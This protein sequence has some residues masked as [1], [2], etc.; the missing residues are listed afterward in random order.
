MLDA[1]KAESTVQPERIK[2]FG[3]DVPLYP[4]EAILFNDDVQQIVKAR[5]VERKLWKKVRNSC[6]FSKTPN[7]GA[8]A[9]NSLS[10][11]KKASKTYLASK[12]CLLAALITDNARQPFKNRGSLRQLIE[13]AEAYQILKALNEPVEIWHQPKSSGGIRT[14]Q[15]FGP[16]ARA[17]QRMVTKLIGLTFEPQ[18][19]QFPNQGSHAKTEAV[20]HLLREEDYRYVIE[21]DIKDFYPSFEEGKL[22]ASLPLPKE[23]I[24]QI[25]LAVDAPRYFPG[26]HSHSFLDQNCPGIP[27]GS[28]SSSEL[29]TWCVAYL[30]TW[31]KVQDVFVV[32]HVDNFFLVG[33]S[34]QAVEFASKALGFQLKKL[35]GGSFQGK[36]VQRRCVDEGFR[37]LGAWIWRE[38]SSIIAHPTEHNLQKFDGRFWIEHEKV[39]AGFKS[40][41]K[42]CCDLQRIFALQDYVR[43]KN[44]V[45]GWCNAFAFCDDIE[46]IRTDRKYLLQQ[47]A[48]QYQ[49]DDAELKAASDRS[50]KV[51]I[52][53]YE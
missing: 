45:T 32:N 1:L 10:N 8:L 13:K 43:L 53:P 5:K 33:R 4:C 15:K 25:I 14:I 50:T 26:G 6:V 44:Y 31:L 39:H 40:A 34:W 17:S 23:A 12:S 29:A 28:V 22:I 21:I 42:D 46:M 24:R 38:G 37:M 27:Q 47:I 35:P 18:D 7:T 9:C 36:K 3:H 41:Q 19:F 51:R 11:F 52:D 49:I 16:V 2:V 20:L 48:S 30:S